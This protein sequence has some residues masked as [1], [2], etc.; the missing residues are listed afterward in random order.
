[1]GIDLALDTPSW[2]WDIV[3]INVFGS[4]LLGALI[5]WFSLR[6]TPWWVPGVGSGVLGG[7]TTFSAMAAPHPNAPLRAG[8][9]LVV[10]L[11]AA[12]V[13]AAVGWAAAV[14]LSHRSGHSEPPRDP[15]LVE[16]EIEGFVSPGGTTA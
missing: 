16:S 10:T 5:G 12:A 2:Q 14:W 15:E 6:S 8:L 13:A 9:M 1:M 11:A 7:F 4:A 3:A